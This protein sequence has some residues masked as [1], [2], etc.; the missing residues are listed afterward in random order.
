VARHDEEGDEAKDGIVDEHECADGGGA[1][2]VMF[3]TSEVDAGP[4]R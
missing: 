4:G 2:N 1:D 3:W